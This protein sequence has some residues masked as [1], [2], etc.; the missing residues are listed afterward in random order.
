MLPPH[1]ESM[2]ESDVYCGVKVRNVINAIPIPPAGVTSVVV[3]CLAH[4]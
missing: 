3:E 2:T 1:R 4:L